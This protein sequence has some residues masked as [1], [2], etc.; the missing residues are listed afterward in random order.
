MGDLTYAFSDDG[1]RQALVALGDSPEAV[2]RTLQAMGLRG[3][4]HLCRVCPVAKYLLLVIEGADD[5]GVHD[6]K[7]FAF[8]TVVE[9]TDVASE[10]ASTEL[11]VVVQAFVEDFDDG[12]FPDLI[13]GEARAA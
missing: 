3:R 1:L 4:R 9:Y 7:A 5:I 6:Y 2:G 10:V 11:P 12:R 8:R 13:E